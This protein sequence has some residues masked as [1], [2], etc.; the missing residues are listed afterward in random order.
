M[1]S[2]H[3]KHVMR[4]STVPPKTRRVGER[5]TLNLSRAQTYSRWC[6]VLAQGLWSRTGAWSVA[7]SS[8]GDTEDPPCR[9]GRCPLDLSRLN[10]LPFLW[11]LGESVSSTGI[12][13][14]VT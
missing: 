7:G 12:V 3:G 8:S 11:W 1:V 4:S 9:G 6:G 13:A 10:V 14:L 2:D 5:C